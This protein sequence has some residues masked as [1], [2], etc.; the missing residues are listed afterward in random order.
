MYRWED[1][2]I[3]LLFYLFFHRRF[4]TGLVG[5]EETS[6]PTRPVENIVLTTKGLQEKKTHKCWIGRRWK[7]R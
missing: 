3:N 6:T 7:N 1:F 5:V 2:R 4:L